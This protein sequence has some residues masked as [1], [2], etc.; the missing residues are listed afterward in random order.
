MAK[1]LGLI[2]LLFVLTALTACAAKNTDTAQIDAN[3]VYIISQN[4]LQGAVKGDGTV[5]FKPVYTRLS[6]LTDVFT[7]E[8]KYIEIYKADAGPDR[9]Q[10]GMPTD[11]KE[12]NALYDLS[13]KQIRPYLQ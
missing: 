5:L 7:N 11:V 1:K 2:L 12:S 8:Q 10:Y 9:D 6:V 13:G 3:K 4:G